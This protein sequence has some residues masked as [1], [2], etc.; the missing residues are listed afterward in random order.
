MRIVEIKE[1]QSGD[2]LAKAVETKNGTVMLGAGTV[3][4]EQYIN[5]L[6]TIR[7]QI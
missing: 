6:K 4:T 7:V 5:R 3:L 2:V 1:L